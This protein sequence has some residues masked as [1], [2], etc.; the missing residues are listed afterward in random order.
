MLLCQQA[1][2]DIVTIIQNPF[3]YFFNFIKKGTTCWGIYKIRENIYEVSGRIYD[4]TGHI[5]EICNIFFQLLSKKGWWEWHT[6]VTT[7][8][9]N[10]IILIRFLFYVKN[11]RWFL[12]L[13]SG[14]LKLNS[15]DTKIPIRVF[16]KRVIAIFFH[17]YI[18]LK[19]LE[20][21]ICQFLFFF[22]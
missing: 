15:A 12:P 6:I 13:Q 1:F 9:R 19:L 7:S 3:M 22:S 4:I 10:A 21:V 5:Y 18:I 14:D 2:F 17:F 20:F 11:F 8:N 16:S